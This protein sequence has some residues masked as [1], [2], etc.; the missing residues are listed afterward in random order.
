MYLA[1]H[2]EEAV[3]IFGGACS[4][5]EVT[6]VKIS[7]S[8]SINFAFKSGRKRRV[9]R[10]SGGDNFG[11][12]DVGFERL[13]LANPLKEDVEIFCGTSSQLALPPMKISL[14]SSKNSALEWKEAESSIEVGVEAWKSVW[15]CPQSH[16]QQIRLWGKHIPKWEDYLNYLKRQRLDCHLSQ[17]SV[18]CVMIVFFLNQVSWWSSFLSQVS[19]LSSIECRDCPLPQS[20]LSTFSIKFWDCLLSQSSV[21]MNLWTMSWVMSVDNNVSYECGRQRD[22]RVD[23]DVSHTSGWQ[24]D[25]CGRQCDKCGQRHELQVWTTWVSV[26]NIMSY[27]CEQRCELCVWTTMW[28][29]RVDNDVNYECGQQLE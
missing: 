3:E 27:E 2:L 15:R 12:H 16:N 7:S 14:S 19:R 13:Y 23:N 24:C 17:L 11:D 20:S 21:V 5:L 28:I 10:R 29:M 25:K 18:N 8:S 9:R 26:D 4:R 22:L 6:P 1:N